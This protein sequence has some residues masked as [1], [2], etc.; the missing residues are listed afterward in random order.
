[1]TDI[2][3]TFDRRHR[4]EATGRYSCK[5]RVCG[6]VREIPEFPTILRRAFYETIPG[7]VS[8]LPKTN[9]IVPDLPFIEV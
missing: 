1:M 2:T 3:R 9:D 5:C 6:L 8:P 4:W 7:D